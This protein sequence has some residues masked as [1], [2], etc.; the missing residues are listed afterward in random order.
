M[1]NDQH[2]GY[3][4]SVKF[5]VHAPP[6][7]VMELLTD[8]EFIKDWSGAEALIEKKPGGRFM[9]FDGWVKGTIIKITGN[10]LSYT[11]K[12]SEW[13]AGTQESE[14]HY[15]LESAEHGTE[16][17]VDHTGLPDEEELENY[18]EGWEKYFFGP[19]GEF[20]A[21]RNL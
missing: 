15:K 18:K 12:P 16:V 20:L 2:T 1:S 6:D 19:I 10:E 4:L 17:Q 13:S 8:T 9:M 14:V 7:E 21:N 11:W 3:S 5:F